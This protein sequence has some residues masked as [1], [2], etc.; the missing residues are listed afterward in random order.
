[1]ERPIRIGDKVYTVASDDNYLDQVGDDFEPHM[2]QLFRAL[3]QP[4]DVVADIGANIGLTAILFSQLAQGVIAFE[5][6]PS[7]YGFL[8]ANVGRAALTNVLTVN[9]GLGK[10]IEPLTITFAKTNRSGGYVSDKIRPKAQHVT[11]MI[12]I[13][14][15]DNYF[16][17]R[18]SVPSFLKIDVEGF[19]QNVIMGG[20]AFLERNKPV[21]VME[22]NHFCLD[23]LQRITIPDFLDFLRT[24][25]PHL[26]AIDTDNTTIVNL[27]VPDDAY[28]V[29][30]EHVVKR[31]FPN[32]VGGFHDSLKSKLERLAYSANEGIRRRSFP[33]PQVSC[34]EGGIRAF[35]IPSIIASRDV[36]EI[37]VEI[38][39]GGKEDWHC[40]GAHPI[41]LCYHWQNS[42]GSYLVYDGVRTIL[43]NQIVQAGKSVHETAT[44]VAPN[45]EGKF[46]LILTI[47]QE[48]VRWFEGGDF[49]AEVARV[50]VSDAPA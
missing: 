12:L 3:V 2:A 40:Y 23:V 1:M 13:E 7:T 19:E 17:N 43:K 8:T 38:R 6:S 45:S 24:I 27:H 9:L 32:I 46:T 15:L 48:G 41:K 36:L 44:I 21:V 50:T 26:Y 31:R 33:T 14:T 4:S 47:V 29:M 49:G 16:Q 18:D 39:N 34:P 20:A 11:E 28:F 5:P 30:H 35:R 10:Q 22:M 42:D 37:P 25:F